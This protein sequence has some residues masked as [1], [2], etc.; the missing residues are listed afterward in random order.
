MEIKEG[1]IISAEEWVTIP[2]E[3]QDQLNTIYKDQGLSTV[4]CSGEGII[5]SDTDSNRSKKVGLALD[6][7]VKEI[8]TRKVTANQNPNSSAGSDLFSYKDRLIVTF[9]MP[10]STNNEQYNRER[11]E[12]LDMT[13]NILTTFDQTP[14][15]NYTS[16]NRRSL[17]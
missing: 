3:I 12:L 4:K 15:P 13:N 17:E 1:N 16:T 9:V 11:T 2:Q 7:A 10:E 14:L 6:L 5:L 8:T